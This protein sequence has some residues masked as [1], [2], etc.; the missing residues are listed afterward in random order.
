MSPPM[1]FRWD[2]EAMAPLKPKLAD[3]EFVIGEV[4][5]LVEHHERSHASHAHYFAAINEAWLNLPE[6]LSDRFATDE[7]L[8]KF[9][10]IKAGYHDE[11]SIVCSSKAEALRVAAFIKP[12]DDYA[13]VTVSGPV[14]TRY[15]AKSQSLKAMG[16][17]VF[18]ASKEAVLEILAAMLN[19]EPQQLSSAAHGAPVPNK[20]GAVAA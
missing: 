4:Y 11:Q 1:P 7:H 3:R 16:K 2:G 20:A 13:I 18:Q 9:A 14:V 17:F 12:M 19:V 6:A 5:S 15:T 8:R 10:L